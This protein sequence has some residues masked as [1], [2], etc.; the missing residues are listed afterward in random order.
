MACHPWVRGFGI[1]HL[2]VERRLPAL[3][4]RRTPV[5]ADRPGAL[6]PGPQLRLRELAVG[7]L[8]PDAVGVARLQVCH[9]DLAG[10]LVLAALGNG[11]VDL[12]E[13]VRVAV[14]HR[15]RSL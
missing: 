13:G 7:L 2:L 10:Y 14:E 6:D 1:S 3:E 15:R 4:H 8:Q 12:E 9:Q 11:E 5:L